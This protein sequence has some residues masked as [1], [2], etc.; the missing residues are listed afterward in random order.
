MRE[1]L[2][3]RDGEEKHS[4]ESQIQRGDFES[5]KENHSRCFVCMAGRSTNKL[6]FS[7]FRKIF[8]QTLSLSRFL[9]VSL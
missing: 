1:V 3:F 7:A 9:S 8:F 2:S 6:R 4:E 5:R